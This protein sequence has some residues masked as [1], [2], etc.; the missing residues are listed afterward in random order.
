MKKHTS[1]A[2]DSIA[3]LATGSRLTKAS[4]DSSAAAI[5][6]GLSSTVSVLN[7]TKLNA[8]NAASLI[9]VAAGAMGDQLNLITS[10]QTLAAKA[11]DASLSSTS[12]ALVKTSTNN[13]LHK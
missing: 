13:F 4:T 3:Q 1:D 6:K 12:R 10:L 7:Q 5:A 8:S 9:Q 11:T 2:A